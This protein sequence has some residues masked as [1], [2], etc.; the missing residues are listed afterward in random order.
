MGESHHGKW[1]LI[2]HL[3]LGWGGRSRNSPQMA[4]LLVAECRHGPCLVCVGEGAGFVL[5][6]AGAGLC[7]C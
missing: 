7:G 3:G 5:A 4:S 1:R 6:C 2:V